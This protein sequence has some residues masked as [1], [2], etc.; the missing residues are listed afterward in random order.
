MRKCL[1]AQRNAAAILREEAAFRKQLA[2][3]AKVR[4]HCCT[5]ALVTRV[6]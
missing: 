1:F 5:L 3:E 4:L 2:D 6:V